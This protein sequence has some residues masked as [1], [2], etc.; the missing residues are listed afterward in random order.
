MPEA[1]PARSGNHAR[2]VA[3]VTVYAMPTPRPPKRL[4]VRYKT[5]GA[6]ARAS[7]D[8]DTKATRMKTAAMLMVTCEFVR[9]HTFAPTNPPAQ[10]IHISSVN[11]NASVAGSHWN[12]AAIGVLNTDH[13]YTKPSVNIARQAV[14]NLTARFAASGLLSLERLIEDHLPYRTCFSIYI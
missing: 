13:P 7:S 14:T 12:S 6:S 3:I 2:M 10:N 5:Q 8:V 4:Y 11:V 1:V 9:S